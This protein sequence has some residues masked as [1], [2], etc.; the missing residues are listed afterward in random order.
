[1]GAV[2]VADLVLRAG[3]TVQMTPRRMVGSS[4]RHRGHV[5]DEVLVAQS[6]AGDMAA[7]EA[8][9]GRYDWRVRKKL[10]GHFLPGAELDDLDLQGHVAG[11][12]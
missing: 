12:I 1:M 3:G 6:H 11:S 4:H 8:L 5:S 7:L 9:V 10:R 2:F